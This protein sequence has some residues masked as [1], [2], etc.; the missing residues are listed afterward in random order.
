M[1]NTPDLCDE[2]STEVSVLAPLYHNY[3]GKQ[4]FSGQVETVKCFEDNSRVKELLA[5]PGN[6]KVLVVDGG[7]SLR[8]ALIGDLIAAEAVKNNWQ[9]I[10]IHGCCRDVHELKTMDFGVRALNSMPIRSIRRGVGDI[11]VPVNVAG[12]SVDPGMWL[13]ADETGIIVSPKKLGG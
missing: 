11:G 13:Y 3:G 5:T 10:L 12:V 9:G 1:W 2:F 8:C 4:H 7:G 6:G